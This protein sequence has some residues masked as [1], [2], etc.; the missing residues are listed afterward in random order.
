MSSVDSIAESGFTTDSE[1]DILEEEHTSKTSFKDLSF[2]K[3]DSN[4]GVINFY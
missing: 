1:G 3:D 2:G 4:E